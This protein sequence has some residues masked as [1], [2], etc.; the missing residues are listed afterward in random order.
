MREGN[1]N[2]DQ[3][4]PINCE[5]EV[6]SGAFFGHQPEASRWNEALS[7]ALGKFFVI[8]LAHAGISA[9]SGHMSGLF[10]V[11]WN[12]ELTRNLALI[13]VQQYLL[14]PRIG[15]FMEMSRDYRHI[16]ILLLPAP[17]PQQ[18]SQFG[19]SIE[20]PMVKRMPCGADQL[21]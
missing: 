10:S 11:S 9:G 4:L 17:L 21:A 14:R 15:N 6:L 8:F 18:V 16:Y 12:T 20:K 5:F 1:F 2:P 7:A 19:R 13:L 3:F